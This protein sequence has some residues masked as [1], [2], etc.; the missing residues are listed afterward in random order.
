MGKDKTEEKPLDLSTCY[1]VEDYW[2]KALAQIFLFQ[3][4]Q[5]PQL[6]EEQ[7][8]P[9][10]TND[11]ATYHSTFCLC[12]GEH[13]GPVVDEHI[14]PEVMMLWLNLTL[15]WGSCSSTA[16]DWK[17]SSSRAVFTNYGA[18][19]LYTLEEEEHVK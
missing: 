19:Y 5:T 4:W 7:G 15:F 18:L 13:G 11:S 1:K 9:D 6:S 10:P 14:Q 8:V 16:A 17:H 12:P 2:T 3:D